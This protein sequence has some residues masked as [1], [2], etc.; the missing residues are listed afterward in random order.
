MS[1]GKIPGK[2]KWVDE[3]LM[4]QK[5]SWG[6]YP[7]ATVDTPMGKVKVTANRAYEYRILV[8]GKQVYQ[9]FN[10]GDIH[11]RWTSIVRGV[12]EKKGS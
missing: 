3:F 11:E 2:E 8:N 1:N 4:W 7:K 10:I 9:S 12:G 6:E 5:R